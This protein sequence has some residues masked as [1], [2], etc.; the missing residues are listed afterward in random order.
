[1]DTKIYGSIKST[2]CGANLGFADEC[3]TRFSEDTNDP[4]SVFQKINKVFE[5]LPLAAKISNKIFCVS[6]GI[7]STIQYLDEIN[8]VKRP[9][10]INYE[11]T[12]KENKIVMDLLWS[13]P[14][15]NETQAETRVR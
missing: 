15:T 2:V 5:Y 11:G 1:V 13:D 6:S 4:N 8:K 7:G 9:L 14:V 3:A 10:Q 12:S